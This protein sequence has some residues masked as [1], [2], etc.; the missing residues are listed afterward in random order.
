MWYARP[1]SG[2][3][4]QAARGLTPLV[5]RQEELRLLLRRWE[6][7]REG[8]G[9]LALIIGEPGIGKSRLVAEFHDRIRDAR[10][11][12]MESTG[13]Q[14]FEN[15][16]FHAL[17]E[18][19]SQWLEL[20]GGA[21]AR[22]QFERLE[23]AL[24]STGLRVSEVAPLIA[25]LLQLPLG[26]RYPQFNLAAEEKR[27]RLLA[28][29][30]GWIL[31]AARLQP[32]VMVVE[33]LHWLDPSTLELQQLLAEQGATVPLMLLYTAR[34]E[35]HASWPMRT[36]HSQIA[37][38]RLSS[39]DVR[40]MVA[41]VAAR[42]VLNRERI[43][44]VVERTGGVPLF[45]EELTR[46]VVEGSGASTSCREIPATLH[47]SL[48]ARLD[49]LG[50]AKET[51]QIGAVIGAEFSY[52]ILHAVYPIS[53]EDLQGRVKSATDAELIYVRGVPPDATY[54]FKHSLIRDAAYGALLR[55]RRKELH[56]Q[57]AEILSQQFPERVA[58]AP[59]LLAHHYTEAGLLEQAIYCWQRAGQAA[60]ERSA[61]AE[62][63]SHLTKGLEV[64]ELLP[65]GSERVKQELALLTNLGPA[66][67][68]AKGY[69]AP[70]VERTFAQAREL[71]RRIGDTSELFSA[72]YG[73][74]WF[75]FV[76]AR[77]DIARDQ[78][79]DLLEF[80]E[81]HR[82]PVMLVTA[83]RALGYTQYDIGNFARAY[84]Q[85]E[86][87]MAIYSP[88]LHSRAVRYGGTDPGVGCLCFMAM[89]LW[90]R[91]YPGQALERVNE[92]LRLAR[93]L[94]HPFSLSVSLSL[95][96]RVAQFRREPWIIREQS[97]ASILSS[98]E[99]GFPLW[100]AEAIMLKGWTLA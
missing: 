74:W 4:L 34:P 44:A 99:Q 36:H 16:P 13:Q 11:I 55:S 48:M 45:V 50:P 66:F 7:T 86:Q 83:H 62:A 18:M 79:V 29:L 76:S 1:G 22:E 78:A 21:D 57:I 46:A 9:Q 75:H 49:R 85:F 84:E 94:A 61:N 37:L 41:R 33:D 68:A 12:W 81:R 39:R 51:I 24:A 25:D 28:A 89:A 95:A 31:G 3:R 42:S 2:G 92:A 43:E 19:L 87:A 32:L 17:I 10:H 77:L 80:A 96:A 5:G 90:Y 14:L 40:E 26:D 38:N 100:L 71:C 63:I 93:E 54:Q 35:F 91:G 52:R 65:D 60:I 73:L 70:E 69:A 30:S 20:Q 64:L 88:Q 97:D 59:E 23:R 47:D 82:D 27:R 98:A 53:N 8:Q 67:I 56:S 15:T 58:S 6:Q 72:L